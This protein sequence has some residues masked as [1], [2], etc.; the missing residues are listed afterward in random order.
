MS[1]ATRPPDILRGAL[2]APYMYK[3]FKGT[4]YELRKGQSTE[5]FG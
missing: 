4:L 2:W 3:Y 5:G 1:G